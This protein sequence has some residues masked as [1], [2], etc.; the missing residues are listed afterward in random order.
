MGE[1][2]GRGGNDRLDEEEE[3][4][5]KVNANVASATTVKVVKAR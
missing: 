5:R 2:G 3:M 1:E 4:Y